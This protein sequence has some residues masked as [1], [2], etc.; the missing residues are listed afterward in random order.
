MAFQA[1]SWPLTIP[2]LPLPLPELHNNTRL[3]KWMFCMFY[4]EEQWPT[5]TPLS[6]I[7]LS[8][9]KNHFSASFDLPHTIQVICSCILCCSLNW[10]SLVLRWKFTKS[11]IQE[12][13]TSKNIQTFTWAFNFLS[14]ENAGFKHLNFTCFKRCR[15]HN[16]WFAGK[17]VVYK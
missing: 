9:T 12:I 10:K 14:K 13:T 3:P 8:F 16:Y 2:C 11:L 7:C 4:S 15:K 6:T 17:Y 1:L 5:V